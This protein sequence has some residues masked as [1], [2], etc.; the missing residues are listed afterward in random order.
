MGAAPCGS[1]AIVLLDYLG[2]V[3]HDVMLD[4]LGIASEHRAGALTAL[5]EFDLTGMLSV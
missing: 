4:K 5:P 2:A 3:F 1:S